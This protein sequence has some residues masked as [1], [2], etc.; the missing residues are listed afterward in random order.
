MK[1]LALDDFK[2]LSSDKKSA[3]LF[4]LLSENNRLLRETPSGSESNSSYT[5]SSKYHHTKTNFNFSPKFSRRDYSIFRETLIF[6]ICLQ[7]L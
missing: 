6:N 1:E 5:A 4:K 2:K 3:E 7:C